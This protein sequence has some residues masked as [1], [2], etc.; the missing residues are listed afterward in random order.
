MDAAVLE[1]ILKVAPNLHTAGAFPEPVF[2]AIARHAG[3]REIRYSAETGSGASTLLFSHLSHAHTVF[4]FDGGS[5][6]IVNVRESSLLL[7]GVV[8][9][10][11]GPTQSTL[12]R[13]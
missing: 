7:P 13:H 3:S 12:P 11:E 1:S 5:N 9:F 2:R 8:T 6:S 4:A 10:V